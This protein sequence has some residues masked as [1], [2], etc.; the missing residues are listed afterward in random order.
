MTHALQ[1][2]DVF[3]VP[4]EEDQVPAWLCFNAAEPLGEHSNPTEDLVPEIRVFDHEDDGD[5]DVFR[6]AAPFGQLQRSPDAQSVVDSLMSGDYYGEHATGDSDSDLD[7]ESEYEDDRDP[8]RSRPQPTISSPRTERDAAEDSD[9]I[10]VVKVSRSRHHN[11]NGHD[12]QVPPPP[13]I[14][15][16]ATLR[17]KASKALRSISSA[18]KSSKPRVQDVFPSRPSSRTSCRLSEDDAPKEAPQQP[19]TASRPHTPAAKVSRRL[20][21]MFTAQSIRARSSSASFHD[22]KEKSA[23]SCPS[24]PTL[25]S[26]Y[27]RPSQPAYSSHT[28]LPP[29]N[30]PLVYQDTPTSAPEPQPRSPSPNH[31]SRSTTRRFSKINL[32]NLFTFSSTQ[33]GEDKEPVPATATD[34][35]SGRSTPTLKRK[36]SSLPSTSSESSASGP[37]TPTSAEDGTQPDLRLVTK[38]SSI[39]VQSTSQGIS[40]LTFDDGFGRGLGILP[41]ESSSSSQLSQTQQTPP[42]PT[43]AKQPFYRRFSSSSFRSSME[44]STSVK[45]IVPTRSFT[46]PL[47]SFVKRQPEQRPSVDEV[48][49]SGVETGG[50]DDVSFEMRLDSL[51]FDDISFDADRF[52]L[53]GVLDGR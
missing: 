7:Y 18:F 33:Q 49:D 14:N 46:A 52:I 27:S 12:Y 47:A 20:S 44:S 15:R 9:V 37:H 5:E 3:V 51:H 42:A 6:R 28:H 32:Q 2:P 19:T 35:D 10:E 1:M 23:V 25:S 45:Q 41:S 30:P 4:P 13:A 8:H 34:L 22:P 31:S 53:D 50:K 48:D 11:E 29:S 36:S 21:Q 16:T 39:L 17:A 43:P 24:E 38:R 26:S 40:H